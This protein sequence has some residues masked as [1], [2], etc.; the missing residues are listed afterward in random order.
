M[1]IGLCMVALLPPSA[2]PLEIWTDVARENAHTPEFTTWYTAPG[3]EAPNDYVFSLFTS[4]T[5]ATYGIMMEQDRVARWRDRIAAWV[6]GRSQPMSDSGRYYKQ[7]NNRVY[8]DVKT[9]VD[10]GQVRW[11][12][13]KRDG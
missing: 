9:T 2:P 10:W 7:L 11:R 3:A 6:Q 12:K 1:V 13:W 4:G 5:G 8:V